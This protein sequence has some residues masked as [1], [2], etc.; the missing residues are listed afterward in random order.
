VRDRIRQNQMRAKFDEHLADNGFA[1]R[2]PA[3]EADL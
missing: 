3:G 2:D 1:A